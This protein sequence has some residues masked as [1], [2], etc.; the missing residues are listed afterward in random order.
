MTHLTAIAPRLRTTFNWEALCGHLDTH[1][2]VQIPNILA[3][4]DADALYR[5]LS[6]LE[7]WHTSIGAG[8]QSWSVRPEADTSLALGHAHAHAAS[9][10]GFAYAF[11]HIPAVEAGLAPEL[12]SVEALVQ[13]EAFI[14]IG[15]KL[16]GDDVCFADAQACRYGPGHFLTA[17]NDD[18][19]G[20]H[21]R[22]AY[23]LNLTPEW[24]PDWGGLLL[25][26]DEKG[27][28][29]N[30]LVPAYNVLNIFKVPVAHSVSAVAPFAPARRYSIT[31]WMRT[32]PD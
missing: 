21:R 26:H 28:V 14:D 12:A 4:T 5:T 10:Q 24:R 18:V 9:M 29:T 1:G 22:A 17:H 13:S 2:W 20:K 25:F 11:E 16:L 30:G 7:Q 8:K 32:Q 6:G 3:R 15:R 27:R 23:V 31:G 19:A